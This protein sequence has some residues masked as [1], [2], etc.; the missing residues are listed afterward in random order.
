MQ[1]FKRPVIPLVLSYMAG[2]ALG[3]RLAGGYILP[4]T[5]A[6]FSAIH[7]LRCRNRR[8]VLLLSPLLL[9]AALGYLSILPWVAPRFPAHHVV[10]HL[11]GNSVTL[12]GE[13]VS[14]PYQKAGRTKF[15]FAASRL[16][17][18][19]DLHR[20][21]G[22]IR[23]TLSGNVPAIERGQQLELSGKLRDLKNYQNPGGFDYVRMMAYRQIWASMYTQPGRAKILSAPDSTAFGTRVDRIRADAA[24]WIETHAG[25]VRAAVL[26]ALLVGDRSQITPELRQT[27]S[28][29]GVSHI[30]AIS[31]LHIG[32]VATVA[33]A[34]FSWLLRRCSFILE[35]G[36]HRKAAALMT[37]VPVIAYGLLAGMSPSTQRA[38]LM[39]LVFLSAFWLGRE[40][41]PYSSLAAA[42]GAIL[43]V[44]PPSVFSISFQLSFAAVSAILF[45]LDRLRSPK[46]PDRTVAGIR[47]AFS[48]VRRYVIGMVTVSVFAV[49]GTAPLTMVYF[50]QVSLMGLLANLVVVPL[51]GFGVVPVGLLAIC[52]SALWPPFS[53][54][55]LALAAWLLSCVLPVIDALSRFPLASLTTW[56]PT[57][58]EIACYY[59]IGAFGLLLATPTAGRPAGDAIAERG[60]PLTATRRTDR[61]LSLLEGAVFRL[62]KAP[63]G[64]WLRVAVAFSMLLLGADAIFWLHQRYWHRDLKITV[65][66]VGHGNAALVEFPGG[67]TLLVDGGGF[68]DISAF[69]SGER[70]LAPF[71]RGR[72]IMTVDTLLL[73][74]PNSDHMNGLIYI[75]DHFNVRELWTNGEPRDTL[76]YRMLMDSARAQR[77]RTPEFEKLHRQVSIGG[78]SARLLY[79]P[80]DFLARRETEPWRDTNNNSVVLQLVF[81]DHSFLFPGDIT[82]RA[83]V[84]LVRACAARLKST[85][86]VV[87]HHGSRTSSS[88]VFLNA[89]TP[90]VAIVSARDRG[91]NRHP[92]PSVVDRYK[93]HGCRLLCTE[94]QGA[95]RLISDGK[96]LQVIPFVKE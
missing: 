21:S 35:R 1:A 24:R 58:L 15:V 43:I 76:G 65:L 23:V 90:R 83:E 29:A 12:V 95:I 6:G 41:D 9:F 73:S 55:L 79:P 42:A 51:I 52:A 61:L 36:W 22:R 11:N 81:G 92:H 69:D 86:L 31:G 2:I 87:P 50:N 45:G 67:R 56:T 3:D 26:K 4:L 96:R 38:V 5:I 46:R 18:D 44:F 70:V 33:F 91:R 10:H 72:K 16:R 34:F 66:D 89:V 75:A 63:P 80:P 48:S 30:L 78:V 8:E 32:I 68:A 64:L 27:F 93:R 77:V 13:V 19:K 54:H 74:H 57:A 94:R 47:R 7:A 60:A 25:G 62:L 49:W 20:A 88:R 71:L 53:A 14:R 85:V 40:L 28:R 59:S 17:A 84:E 39:T 82:R 37:F